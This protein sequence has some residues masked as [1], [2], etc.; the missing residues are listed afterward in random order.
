MRILERIE[1]KE[2]SKSKKRKREIFQKLR[3]HRF[4]SLAGVPAQLSSASLDPVKEFEM[5]KAS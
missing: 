3:K 5:Q 4:C 1:T 2:V